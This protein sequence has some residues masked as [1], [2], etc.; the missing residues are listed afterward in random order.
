VAA[1][2]V[3]HRFKPRRRPP[4]FKPPPVKHPSIDPPGHIRARQLHPII[5]ANAFKSENFAQTITIN[6]WRASIILRRKLLHQNQPETAKTKIKTSKMKLG[7]QEPVTQGKEHLHPLETKA[8]QRRTEK[9]S[10]SRKQD[11][12]S[13]HLPESKSNLTNRLHHTHPPHDRVV[14]PD[15]APPMMSV[16]SPR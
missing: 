3:N 8:G 2:P 13:L 6:Y 9:A 7:D 14:T 15:A 12:Q 5:T 10:T 4:P 1:V 16:H 11:R